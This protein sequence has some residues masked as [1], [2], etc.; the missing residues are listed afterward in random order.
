MPCTLCPRNC[1]A[2]RATGRG[3]C[4][5]GPAP[6]VARADLH[7]YEEPCISGVYGSGTVFFS[8]CNMACVFCQNHVLR[9]GRVGRPCSDAELADIYLSLAA[10]GAHNI[11]LVTPAPHI[12][13]V[14]RSLMLAKSRGLTIPVV[15]NTN[16]YERADALRTLEGLVDVYLPD[17]KYVSPDLAERFSGTRDYAAAAEEAV[18]EMFRQ[19]G[20]LALDEGGMAKRGLLVRHLVLPNCVFDTRAVLDKLASLFG[21]ELHL[22]LMRQYAPTELCTLPPLNRTLTDR[23]YERAL[24][25]ALSLGFTN[26]LIQDRASASLA[27]TP[28]FTHSQ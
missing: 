16:A 4:G 25:Y 7:A 28:S 1:G 19:V 18:A 3:F 10:R 21:T 11:N 6:L 23:E 2:D 22:S 12:E 17:F 9:S 8:G 15:Y 13:A 27:F 24:Q 20:R 14:A 26:V 5:A